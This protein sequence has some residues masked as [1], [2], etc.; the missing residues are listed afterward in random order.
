MV[1]QNSPQVAVKKFDAKLEEMVEAGC[2]F[3][4]RAER[5]NP[6]A[7]PYIFGTKDGVHI[8]DLDKT[9]V[10]LISAMEELARRA[11]LGEKILFVGTKQQ[12]TDVIRKVAGETG[13]PYIVDRWLGGLFT[14]FDQMKKSLAKLDKMKKEREAGEY[15]K[16]TKKEQLLIDREIARLTRLF[17][18]VEILTALPQL[19]VI[20]DTSREDTALE[21][22]RK[23]GVPIVGIVDTNADPTLVDFPIPAND[24][25]IKSVEYIV[26]KLG[27]AIKDGLTRKPSVKPEE[28][29]IV[30]QA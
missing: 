1:R 2:H 16:F 8:F 25:S 23:M 18:G 5:W 14:N 26:T 12:A 13:M 11:S 27:D 9:R 29:T 20:V 7:A 19:V 22:A 10:L 3:G 28:V 24:D 30:A 15:Q 21:E 6:K 4:H 17:G